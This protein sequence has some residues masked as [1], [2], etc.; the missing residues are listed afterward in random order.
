MRGTNLEDISL[1]ITPPTGQSQLDFVNFG[2]TLFSTLPAI[3]YER[4]YATNLKIHGLYLCVTYRS[5][6]II[7]SRSGKMPYI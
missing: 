2:T 4:E 7:S 3:F 6:R 5:S 1:R